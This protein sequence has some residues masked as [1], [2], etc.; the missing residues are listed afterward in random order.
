MFAPDAAAPG[1]A[2]WWDDR[3]AEPELTLSRP[4]KV[5]ILVIGGGYTGLSA[6]IAAADG[7]ASVCIVD[8]D[9]PGAGAS[10]RN[11]GMF[12]AH[13]RLN[14]ETMK[15]R[16]DE[17]SARGI[18]AEA[19]PALD[20]A[21]GLIDRENIDCDLQQTGRIMLA[22]TKEHYQNLT[23]THDYLTAHTATEARMVEHADLGDEIGT[24]RYFGG[25]L[26]PNHYA[27]HPRKFH[28]GL[29]ASALRRG[30]EVVPDCPVTKWRRQGTGYEVTTPMGAIK[31]GKIIL[32]TNG[33]TTS[34]FP[35]VR[36][37]VFPLPSFIIATE[38]LSPN[39]LAKLA[40]GRRMMV[41]TRA[42]HSYFRLSPDGTRV[43]WGGRAA[44]K[45][46][47]V[48]KGAARLRE[49]MC[50][51]WPELKGVG[52]SHC[53]MGN[54]GYSFNHTPHVGEVEGLHYA[55]GYS[56]SGTVM[57][58]YLGAKAAWRALGDPRGETAFANDSAK[59]TTKLVHPGGTPHFMKLV[60]IWYHQVVDRVQNR[61]AA[62]DRA[63]R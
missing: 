44:M 20:F 10:T 61:A 5:D 3:P 6:A 62:K 39:L 30:V 43:L 38:P 17:D 47:D 19:K 12:G 29:L 41:E 58:P 32:A 28:D 2:Y 55:M 33:Y 18:L 51:I 49:T 13:P 45:H 1:H 36:R 52:L 53:W 35:W 26:L 59:F 15:A 27:I 31:A 22:W 57:A 46:I 63:K 23:K 16:F 34:A 37:R 9:R 4:A 14:F 24:D 54:T 50:E 21:T 7:G 11:G 56:G 8:A 60:D 48:Q 42:R 25:L 40:P